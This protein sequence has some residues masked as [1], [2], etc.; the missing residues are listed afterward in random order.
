MRY[1]YFITSLLCIFFCIRL[2]AQIIPAKKFQI[3][4]EAG[5]LKINVLYKKKNGFILVG[6]QKGLYKFDGLKFNAI[7]FPN[8]DFTDNVTAIHE[9]K[10]GKLWIGFESGR[11]AHV[12][13]NQ[14]V[15]WNPEE[16]TPKQKITGIIS[17][18]N[19]NVWFSTS[20]EG[21]YHTSNGHV[22]LI[23]EEE[24][25][26][27]KNINAICNTNGNQVLAATDQGLAIINVSNPEKGI[28][29]ISLKDGLPDYIITSIFQ[30]NN[31]EYLLGFQDKG[32]CIY[33]H[34]TKKITTPLSANQW[35][36]GTVTSLACAQHKIWIGTE[37]EGVIV[38]D[39]ATHQ[40]STAVITSEKQVS[41]VLIDDFENIWIA[42]KLNSVSRIHGFN[43]TLFPLPSSILFDHLHTILKDDNENFWLTD[44]K[45]HLL[46]YNS[47][48]TKLLSTFILPGINEKTDITS[49]HQDQNGNIW[50]GTV[51]NGLFI[52]NPDKM[53][54]R[55]FPENIAF[56]T[57]T[58]LSVN[59][60]NN[61][62][63]I[64]SLE[65]PFY[66]ET[67]TNAAFSGE[68]FYKELDVSSAGS[69]YIYAIFEDRKGDKWFATDGNGIIRFHK[70]SYT[71]YGKNILNDDR[72]Y[73][74]TEDRKGDIWF[75]TAAH[76]IYKFNGAFHNYGIKE[77]LTD[78]HISS[79]RC[80][81][82][83]NIVIIHKK[84]I[85]VLDPVT[86]KINF[87]NSSNGISRINTED[88][89]ASTLD[90]D[91]NIYLATENGIAEFAPVTADLPQTKTIIEHVSL[92]MKQLDDDH[93]PEFHY[94][95]NNFT[96]SF[97]GLYYTDP[98]QV[99]FQYRLEGFDTSWINTTDRVVTFSKLPPGKYV[100]RIRSAL[101]KNFRFA[102]EATYAFTIM[103]AFYKTWWFILL[104]VLFV[105]FIVVLI[106][107][108]RE[109]SLRH[110]EKLR[111]EKIQFQFEVLR[112]QI[113]PHFL[114]NSFNTL[115][116]IIDDDPKVAI[117]YVEQLSDFFRDI[118]KY[119]DKEIIP[120]E[121]ELGLLQN[122]FYLQQKRFGDQIQIKI[123]ISADEQKNSFIPPLT[124][125]L[126][127]E[128]A[129]KHNTI[130]KNYPLII[131]IDM[132][133]SGVI[134]SNNI[135]SKREIT[136]GEGMGLQNII[137]RYTLL[138]NKTVNINH[139][140]T[141]FIVTLPIIAYA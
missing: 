6:T 140:S 41:D 62:I 87:L 33:N 89:D 98:E 84:G 36:Y 93:L 40:I 70:G 16:G 69:N 5:A 106:V 39:S 139:T 42:G 104:C 129:I 38:I 8:P 108:N 28:H 18:I 141:Q 107:R 9:D 135:T 130:S 4:N 68:H 72:I 35:K 127:M 71:V 46:I 120:L 15:Y 22:Y 126:L 80:D 50:A 60:K 112:N 76:G 100:F 92:F 23:N 63:F 128:N 57:R 86:G 85:D 64:S 109:K 134:V 45:N 79:L 59:G 21:L 54:H 102:S 11:I 83:G 121:E 56:N 133:A 49:L 82:M 132:S 34:L 27:E 118:V 88:L 101:N 31:N 123:S 75:S 19:N 37:N 65:G 122:F 125:Q 113:N 51:G 90:A 124:L 58:I 119:R 43:I 81:K 110:L 55:R 14:L 77:G 95:D 131:S 52:I 1:R 96:F 94:E 115:I 12:I 74:I 78:L 105:T 29:F 137:N 25:L 67:N 61:K 138:S 117:E 20:G 47:T 26:K 13:N 99:L 30:I 116:S 91:G 111:S 97:T 2:V 3:E 7:S 103:Q 44:Q 10:K 114:F 73:S 24:G 17:D 66:I 53:T 48:L 136:K 32:I